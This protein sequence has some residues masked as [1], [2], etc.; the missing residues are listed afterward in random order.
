[1]VEAHQVVVNRAAAIEVTWNERT[2]V[3]LFTSINWHSSKEHSV[4]LHQ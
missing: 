1:M 4:N 2:N 3:L